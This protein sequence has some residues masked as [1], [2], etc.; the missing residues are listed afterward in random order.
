MKIIFNY[1]PIY[2]PIF[3]PH[4]NT[5]S[6]YPIGI[7]FHIDMKLLV[8]L[9]CHVTAKMTYFCNSKTP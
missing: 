6:G 2:T 1:S 7:Q 5:L 3:S 4:G 8:T 9:S